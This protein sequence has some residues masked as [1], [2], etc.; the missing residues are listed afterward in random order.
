MNSEIFKKV[1]LHRNA[2]QMYREST[3][4]EVTDHRVA[5]YNINY[6]TLTELEFELQI[7][8]LRQKPL[9]KLLTIN[10]LHAQE[11]YKFNHYT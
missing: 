6:T 2:D 5:V 3:P 1:A 4:F 8:R 11:V 9:S 10:Y 7:L